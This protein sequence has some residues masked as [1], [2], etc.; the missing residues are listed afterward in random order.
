MK[1]K[2]LINKVYKSVSDWL[3]YHN[4]KKETRDLVRES[5]ASQA[6][7]LHSI[8]NQFVDN[9]LGK[10]VDKALGIFTATAAL[11]LKDN[12]NKNLYESRDYPDLEGKL[13]QA[14]DYFRTVRDNQTCSKVVTDLLHK[15]SEGK[16][17]GLPDGDTGKWC[18]FFYSVPELLLLKYFKHEYLKSFYN[19]Y[20]YCILRL[21]I[22]EKKKYHKQDPEN[23]AVLQ[24]QL[25]QVL[26]SGFYI[27]SFNMYSK[28][29]QELPYSA[30]D[31]I[32]Q[33]KLKM[34]KNEECLY[35]APKIE[36]IKGKTNG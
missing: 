22:F 31:K 3:V 33:L 1:P 23:Y 4:F 10:S 20:M 28:V 30:K 6:F 19:D 2:I 13:S 25:T 29:Y 24:E 16:I 8:L 32:P 18:R 26:C 9:A 12:I 7:A 11:A 36:R 14:P 35:T 34:K 17:K 27:L 5:N 21:M 15:L